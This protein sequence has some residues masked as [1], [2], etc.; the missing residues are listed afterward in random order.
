MSDDPWARAP[1][2]EELDALRAKMDAKLAE[3]KADPAKAAAFRADL[4]GRMKQAF[5]KLPKWPVPSHRLISEAFSFL[6]SEYGFTEH[7]RTTD[8]FLGSVTVK[9]YSSPKVG[10]RI[11]VGGIDTGGFCFISFEDK[12]SGTHCDFWRL[13]SERKPEFEHPLTA[14]SMEAAKAHLQAYATA[15]REHAADVLLGDFSACYR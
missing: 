1:S 2:Q 9:E 14:E 7:E 13:L 8:G 10:V 12:K 6:V 5:D 11:G 15:V 3:L 4:H